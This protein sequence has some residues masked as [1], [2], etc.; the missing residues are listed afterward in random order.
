MKIYTVGHEKQSAESFFGALRESGAKRVVDVRF[1]GNSRS[2]GFAKASDLDFLLKELCGV[3]YTQKFKSSLSPP[4]YMF[5]SYRKGVRNRSELEAA[6]A[7]F[8]KETSAAN[9]ARILGLG[10]GDVLL[11][12]DKDPDNC[13]RG[14]LAEHLRQEWKPF[15]EMEAIHL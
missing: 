7:S 4:N 12:G 8:L 15:E 3:D 2:D 11:G 1:A 10:D 9:R 5:N 6:Y 13:W 14:V